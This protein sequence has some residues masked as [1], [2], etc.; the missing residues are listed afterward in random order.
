MSVRPTSR[1]TAPSSSTHA[2]LICI[3]CLSVQRSTRFQP[4]D[5]CVIFLSSDPVFSGLYCTRAVLHHI[6]L[7]I[8]NPE[9]PYLLGL[10]APV[11]RSTI[12]RLNDTCSTPP[13]CLA[14]EKD[15]E[16]PYL[17]GL[18]APVQR[19]TIFRLNDTCT[20]H[21]IALPT[22][23]TRRSHIYLA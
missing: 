22:K 1:D 5:S 14:D 11:Q 16:V 8:K 4:S 15:S 21:H 3:Q 23:K 19:S 10:S 6:A 12:F 2:V 9:D 17:L 20:L 18:S 13:Y 7:S